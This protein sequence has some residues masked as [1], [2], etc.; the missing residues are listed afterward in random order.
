MSE[1]RHGHVVELSIRVNR[2][3]ADNYFIAG[4]YSPN[5]A[6]EASGA[7]RRDRLIDQFSVITDVTCAIAHAIIYQATNAA[8]V[9]GLTSSALDARFDS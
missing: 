4:S 7:M 5:P 1:S 8:R 2:R 9:G 3:R 6:P